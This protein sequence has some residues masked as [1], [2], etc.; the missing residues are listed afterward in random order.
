MKRLYDYP[1]TIIGISGG[2]ATGKSTLSRLLQDHYAVI[3]ADRLVKEIYS[4]KE[5][6]AFMFEHYPQ[7]LD[8]YG[9]ID[10]KQ[11]R[12]MF[13]SDDTVK[14][15]IED[16]IYPR[17]PLAFYKEVIKNGWEGREI[18]YDMPLLFEM[19]LHNQVDASICVYIPRVEQVKRLMKRDNISE[20]LANK[21]LDAQMDIEEKKNLA[22]IVFDNSGT[23]I[24]LAEQLC[25]LI[26]SCFEIKGLL[27]EDE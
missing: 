6:D 18:F 22:N 27:K 20:E 17:M 26:K 19:G 1:Y 13:F 16:Y 2:I 14:K 12:E 4:W 23:I 10:F 21:M 8:S 3:C 25:S 15:T 5:T 9:K 11:L 7:V 24:N